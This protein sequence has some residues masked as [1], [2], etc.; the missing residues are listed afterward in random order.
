KT[1]ATVNDLVSSWNGS[2]GTFTR[3]ERAQKLYD[4]G[5][6][7]VWTSNLYNNDPASCSAFAVNLS[8]GAVGDLVRSTPNGLALCH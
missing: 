4:S 5:V 6:P 3:T 2:F 8:G 7:F 1:M